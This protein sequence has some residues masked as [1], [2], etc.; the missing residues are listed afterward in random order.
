MRFR[1]RTGVRLCWFNWLNNA[2]VAL[3]VTRIHHPLCYCLLAIH[4]GD[5]SVLLPVTF[6]DYSRNTMSSS[7]A[8][9]PKTDVQMPDHAVSNADRSAAKPVFNVRLFVV[10]QTQDQTISV[11]RATRTVTEHPGQSGKQ[12]A[13]RSAAVG[14][15]AVGLRAV[16]RYPGVV[17]SERRR[18]TPLGLE[19]C[20]TWPPTVT[21]AGVESKQ[22]K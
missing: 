22:E 7:D 16:Q 3:R 19:A 8:T 14:H 2:P 21:D 20:L 15:A 12:P 18:G 6:G 13:R 9:E 5:T 4:D 1:S 17:A 11:R 10:F